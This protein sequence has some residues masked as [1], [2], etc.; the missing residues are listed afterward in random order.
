MTRSILPPIFER[1]TILDGQLIER[2]LDDRGVI[3]AHLLRQPLEQTNVGQGQA[4]VDALCGHV[5]IVVASACLRCVY[6]RATALIKSLSGMSTK[7]CIP[8]RVSSELLVSLL[9]MSAGPRFSAHTLFEPSS[10]GGYTHAQ[11]RYCCAPVGHRSWR[12]RRSEIE[13]SKSNTFT[14]SC[15]SSTLLASRPL[16]AIQGEPCRG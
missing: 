13:A 9:P 5:A 3:Q 4:D 1:N 7:S 8:P 15:H 16:L 6:E 2:Q 12:H 11:T 14:N 10:S